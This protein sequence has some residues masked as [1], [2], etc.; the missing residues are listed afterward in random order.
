MT[1]IRTKWS[2]PRSRGRR[3]KAADPESTSDAS[4][5]S[6]LDCEGALRK[7][8]YLRLAFVTQW[9]TPEGPG[10]PN[11]IPEALDQLGFQVGVVT[12]TPHYPEGRTFEGYRATG[13]RIER[14]GGLPVLRVPEYPSHDAS[15]ARRMVTLGSFAASSAL[16]GVRAIGAA[17][18]SLVYSSPAT[19]ALAAMRARRKFGTPYVLYVQDLW[20]DSVYAAGAFA[21]ARGRWFADQ[22]IGR[23]VDRS[24]ALA[25]HIVVISPGMKALLVSRGVDPAKVTVVYNWVDEDVIGPAPPAGH[26]RSALGL[27]ES[28]TVMLYAGNLGRVQ[29][30]AAWIEAMHVIRDM[31]D[32][33]LAIIGDGIEK[34]DLIT[35]ATSLKLDTNVHFLDPVPATEISRMGSDADLGVV[36]LVDD[37]LFH[38]TLPSKTQALL[39]QAKAIL[40]SAPGDAA[41]L[42]VESEVGWT[43]R[44]GSADAIASMIREAVLAGHSEWVRRGQ[45]GRR[46]YDEEMSREVGASRL[47]QI[48]REAIDA[49]GTPRRRTLG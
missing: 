12:G 27:A 19:S 25:S 18:V 8:R 43:C 3:K 49:R 5:L 39:A 31:E 21:S 22:T 23:F 9:F 16:L 11:W 7:T 1:A 38:V 41:R 2:L 42:V 15:A 4:G 29:G 48:L 17:D 32:V 36:S 14:A 26:L 47:A 37:P 6:A 34:R 30:L 35:R 24:Y 10:P 13:W 46:L 44:P 33:H 28:A 45:A 40:N 20:P